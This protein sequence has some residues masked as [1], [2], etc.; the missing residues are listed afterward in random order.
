MAPFVKRCP[1]VD[2]TAVQ[3]QVVRHLLI[4]PT[5]C[6]SQISDKCGLLRDKHKTQ[7]TGKLQSYRVASQVS[8]LQGDGRVLFKLLITTDFNHVDFF[9]NLQGG[10][11]FL[12]VRPGEA[13]SRFH[14][15][16]SS[17]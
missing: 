17:I 14:G 7:S 8:S 16:K 15:R 12:G 9:N 6:I 2:R 11:G 13:C 5:G 10:G 3:L 1:G 4:P